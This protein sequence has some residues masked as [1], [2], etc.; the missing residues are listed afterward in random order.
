LILDGLYQAFFTKERCNTVRFI[1]GI[2]CGFGLVFIGVF[3]GQ[4]YRI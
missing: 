2:F 3:L 4:N 1:T